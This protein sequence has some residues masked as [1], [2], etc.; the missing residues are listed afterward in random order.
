M[1]NFSA[2]PLEREDGKPMHIKLHQ[3]PVLP[4][5]TST[6]LPPQ[7]HFARKTCLPF[8][9]YRRFPDFAC[10]V[11]LLSVSNV[12]QF[13]QRRTL[14]HSRAALK[15]A[16]EVS[17]KVSLLLSFLSSSHGICAVR[18]GNKTYDKTARSPLSLGFPSIFPID[19]FEPRLGTQATKHGSRQ[20]R[21]SWIALD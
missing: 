20:A 10:Q 13:L 17:I 15:L 11:S 5:P 18:R 14:P 16:D 3:L 4:L 6:S 8:Y 21:R 2:Q 12:P 7:I 1:G 9:G 19:S